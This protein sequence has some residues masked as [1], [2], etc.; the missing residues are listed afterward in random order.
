MSLKR[1]FQIS[2]LQFR[3]SQGV[4]VYTYITLK[5]YILIC[6]QQFKPDCNTVCPRPL[7]LDLGYPKFI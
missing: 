2:I 1:S 3:F 4:V 7:S 6:Q 5:I